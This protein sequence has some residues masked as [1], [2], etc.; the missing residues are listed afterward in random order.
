MT[1]IIDIIGRGADS[2]RHLSEL[3]KIIGRNER[4]VR[5][6]IEQLRADGAVICSD[7]RGYFL[8]ETVE[9]LRTY[10]RQERVRVRSLHRRNAAAFRLLKEWGQS[11]GG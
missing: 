9:E 5:Q 1:A 2:A 7:E 8:P 11:F 4:A 3:C 10:V 6:E